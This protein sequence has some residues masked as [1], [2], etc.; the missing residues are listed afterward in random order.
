MKFAVGVMLTAFGCFWGSEGA[1]ARW[2]GGDTAL[3]PLVPLI[4]IFGLV[5]TQL[6]ARA[7]SNREATVGRVDRLSEGGKA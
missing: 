7:P 3:V 1:G 2:P 5:L 6:A 4:A